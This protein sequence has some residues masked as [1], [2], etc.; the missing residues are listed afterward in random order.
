MDIR[1]EY[2][3]ALPTSLGLLFGV[4]TGSLIFYVIVGTV[5]GLVWGYSDH[6]LQTSKPQRKAKASKPRHAA[7]KSSR[8][9]KSK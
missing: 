8:R 7:K 5:A 6:M 3:F 4:L 1:K 2:K 9:K